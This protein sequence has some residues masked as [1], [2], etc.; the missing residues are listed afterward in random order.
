VL[1]I[2]AVAPKRSSRFSAPNAGRSAAKSARTD[3]LEIRAIHTPLRFPQLSRIV[4]GQGT[5]AHER[6]PNQGR[7]L[8]PAVLE[9]QQLNW[10]RERDR[11][12]RRRRSAR[13]TTVSPPSGDPTDELEQTPQPDELCSGDRPSF[14]TLE[15]R[16]RLF[17]PTHITA[18]PAPRARSASSMAPTNRS[19]RSRRLRARKRA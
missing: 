15:A 6:G 14:P 8:A 13:A 9:A 19:A 5:I 11:Q 16:C 1:P 17:E 3:P 7:R 2:E 10:S 18:L 4:T 12:Q